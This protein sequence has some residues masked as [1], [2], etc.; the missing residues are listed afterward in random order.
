MLERRRWSFTSTA[1]STG[2]HRSS[3][4]TWH[5]SRDQRCWPTMTRSS[6]MRTGRAY[7]TCSAA[8]KQ[9]T[10]S[11]W[12]NS[13]LDS[14][15]STT[16]QVMSE[17]KRANSTCQLGL[18]ASATG[19]SCSMVTATLLPSVKMVLEIWSQ[20]LEPIPMAWDSSYRP[21]FFFQCCYI[22]TCRGC[23]PYKC[24]NDWYSR[25]HVT[26]LLLTD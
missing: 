23:C 13:E 12:G 2:G 14:T 11:K 20:T 7:R 16:S 22:V 24:I 17:S 25:L 19:T 8:S 5:P 3:I 18:H 15:P 1:G 6:Q 10:P 9:R 21:F 4:L 26:L